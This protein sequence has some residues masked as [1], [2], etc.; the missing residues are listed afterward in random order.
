MKRKTKDEFISDCVKIHGDKYDY[1]LVEYMGS[2]SIIEIIC[3]LHGKFSQKAYSHF[4]SGC[5]KCSD[6]L[7]RN[8]IDTFITN[9]NIIHSNK[10]DYSMVEYKNVYTKVS[11]VCPIHGKFEQTPHLHL[12]S[13][14]CGKCGIDKKRYSKEE[15]LRLCL[16]IHGN[17]YDYTSIEY[18][19]IQTPII[20]S[21]TIHGNFSQLPYVHIRGKG[22]CHEC[23]VVNRQKMD[24]DTFIK[25]SNDIHNGYYDYSI[26]EYKNSRTKVVIICPK[27]GEFS[28]KP[29]SHITK[30]Q[31]CPKCKKR[32]STNEDKWLDSM[33]ITN[34]QKKIIANN[35]IYFVDGFDPITNTVYEFNGDYWHGNP[36]KFN[37]DDI[38]KT[39]GI[40]FGE[41]YDRTI[42]KEN[43]LRSI[44]YNVVKVWESDYLLLQSTK[45]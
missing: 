8:S 28:I 12:R 37:R 6:S 38:N 30:K 23:N 11:I 10:Y 27:H 5:K 17:K 29:S 15:F 26:V 32:I 1:S 31:G 16:S 24:V 7:K 36:H 42:E 40:P 21:C 14:G 41:L 20:V 3:P 25:I 44:G 2:H 18:V 39:I 45:P 22:G 43:N 4:K 34:R 9:S 13:G 33:G 19:D 35:K